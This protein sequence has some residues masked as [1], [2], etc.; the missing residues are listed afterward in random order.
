MM[1]T[2]EFKETFYKNILQKKYFK[3]NYKQYSLQI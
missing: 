2:K 3:Q 1:C